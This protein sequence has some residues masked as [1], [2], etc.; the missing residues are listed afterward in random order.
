MLAMLARLLYPPIFFTQQYPQEKAMSK[1]NE[2]LNA[3]D[4]DDIGYNDTPNQHFSAVLDARLSR[5]SLLR[6]GAA[7]IASAFIG[8][9]ALSAC[10]GSSSEHQ[11]Q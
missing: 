7:S 8:S 5:R 9:S 10:G 4:P 11:L 1:T 6:G 3:I 2:K